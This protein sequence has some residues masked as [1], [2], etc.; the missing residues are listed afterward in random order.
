MKFLL[1]VGLDLG[2]GFFA[3]LD[4]VVKCSVLVEWV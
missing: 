2:D 1:M 4:F 3:G